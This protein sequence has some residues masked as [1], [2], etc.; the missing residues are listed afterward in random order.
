M[1]KLQQVDADT[2]LK[3]SKY[4]LEAGSSKQKAC[5]CL[6]LCGDKNVRKLLLWLSHPSHPIHA[7]TTAHDLA[8]TNS[9]IHD[10]WRQIVDAVLL[11]ANI[12]AV[13]DTQSSR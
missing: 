9:T 11:S 6:Q 4:N 12:Q 3:S 7:C 1:D 2:E 13:T 10:L 8:P 5:W